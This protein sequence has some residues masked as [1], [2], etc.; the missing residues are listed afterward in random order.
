[1]S[2]D[3]DYEK[4]Y[5]VEFESGRTIH[6]GQFTLEDVLAYCAEKHE[7]QKIKTIYQEVYVN[8][9]SIV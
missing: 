4:I 5:M 3:L 6:V 9:E 7:K 2:Y 8:E 1:M